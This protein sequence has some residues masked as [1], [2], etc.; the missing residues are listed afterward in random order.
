M[1]LTFKTAD[2]T[3]FEEDLPKNIS[4]E[5]AKEIEQFNEFIC[6]SITLTLKKGVNFK[7]AGIVENLDDSTVESVVCLVSKP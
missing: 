5:E 6:D 1:K 7:T 2:E 3:L 4:D